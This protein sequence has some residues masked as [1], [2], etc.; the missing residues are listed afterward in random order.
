MNPRTAPP[1]NVEPMKRLQAGKKSI[2]FDTKVQHHLPLY[3][4]L[5]IFRF[6]LDMLTYESKIGNVRKFLQKDLR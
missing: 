3:A 2:F 5:K 6:D 4:L 1:D